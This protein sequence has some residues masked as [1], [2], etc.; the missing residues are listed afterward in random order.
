MSEADVGS[1]SWINVVPLNRRE[2]LARW[3]QEDVCQGSSYASK[4]QRNAEFQT[5]IA[6]G[7]IERLACDGLREALY[8][9]RQD[10]ETGSDFVTYPRA[11]PDGSKYFG[12]IGIPSE[13]LNVRLGEK[14]IA[15]LHDDNY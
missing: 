13:P 4:R 12:S 9:Q 10:I 1:V 14:G 8:K 2:K 11:T 5:I 3:W 6:T 15:P 7:G